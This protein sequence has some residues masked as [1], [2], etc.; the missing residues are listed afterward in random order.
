MT[1]NRHCHNA[2]CVAALA[3]AA[4]SA[5]HSPN[6]FS[7][8]DAGDD[9][10]AV[11][12]GVAPPTLGPIDHDASSCV[13]SLS[14]YDIP[15]D[16]CD[17]D[18]DGQIDNAVVCDSDLS[19]N[20]DAMAFARALGLCQVA[21]D[22]DTKWGVLSAAFS[23]GHASTNSPAAAQHGILKKFGSVVVPRDGAAL[24]VLSTG[25]A[26]EED[27][28]DG[29][30]FK[31]IKEGMQVFAGNDAPAGYPKVSPECPGVV[32]NPQVH[33]A[34]NLKLVI[35]VPA[36]AQGFAFDFDFWSG[37]WPE[38]VCSPFNDS[39]IA[40]LSS[41]AFNGGAPENITFDKKNNP[42]SV[43]NGFFDRCTPNTPTAC[44]NKDISPILATCPGGV[45]ELAGTGFE[46][47]GVYCGDAKSTGGGATG[48]LTSK[49][50]V[51]PGETIALE[52]MI[53]DTGDASYDSTVLLD[54]FVW[55][56]V[57]TSTGTVRPPPK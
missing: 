39:F 17:N 46:K 5:P 55:Q 48:W 32:M 33:D 37:E 54:H 30:Y 8:R 16:H 6:S 45:A 43:N 15:D 24:G 31:G 34:I 12:A 56:G 44:R 4:C 27:A 57:P 38:Y 36:N 9:D 52:L 47:I 10:A 49:A 14:N 41:A 21:T 40:Y 3:A 50:P 53:W 13:S 18:G 23:N 42:I 2:V 19:A 29:P 35:R 51:K 28:D 7:V 11:D 22:T 25:S 20:G 1:R 26:T